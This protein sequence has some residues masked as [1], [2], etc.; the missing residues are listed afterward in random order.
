MPPTSPEERIREM[1]AATLRP[2]TEPRPRPLLSLVLP[3]YN[4]SAILQTNLTTLADYLR[5]LESR[6]RWEMVVVDDGSTDGTGAIAD[7]FART[8]PGVRVVHHVVNMNLG[9]ALR[10]GFA[11]CRGD[12][13]VVLDVDLSYEPSHVERLLS[14]L[15]S[16]QADVVVASP[17]MPGGKVSQVPP[18]RLQLSKWAN[19]FLGF[20]AP[21]ANLRTITGMVRGYRREFLK[22]L[23]LRALGV[24]INSEIIYKGMLL[25]GR[26]IEI[27]AH[28]D[29]SLQR[30]KGKAR[31]SS[32]KIYR[33]IL[34]YVLAGF[35]FRPFMFF[36]LPGGFLFLVS[37][38][39][40]AWIF[41]NAGAVYAQLPPMQ[42]TF[43]DRFSEAVAQTF[44]DR[45]HAFLV[46]G[47]TLVISLQLVSLGILA[48]QSKRYFEELFHIASTVRRDVAPDEPA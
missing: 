22:S 13:V 8:H 35:I 30:Q 40:I 19:R 39:V 32:F 24:D 29:W 41:V 15:E 34:T 42:G 16:T 23:D 36:L 21:Q 2:A 33:G 27:P 6:Y 17:Y 45:P 26:I 7:E 37:I 43:D 1:Q 3:A 25:R 9:Q 31:V 4:E 14:T 38:Y 11:H 48:L 20:F 47:V 12:F 10:T 46:G 18:V 44:R 28:L 5:G